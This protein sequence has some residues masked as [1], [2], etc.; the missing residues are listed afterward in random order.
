M[1]ASEETW[2]LR[3]TEPASIRLG[4]WVAFSIHLQTLKGLHDRYQ[5]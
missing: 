1:A 3:C 5:G 4:F 2:V